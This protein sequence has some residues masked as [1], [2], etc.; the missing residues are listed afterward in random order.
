MSDTDSVTLQQLPPSAKLVY[1][2]LEYADEPL[3][4]GEIAD[5]TMLPQRTVRGALANLEEADAVTEQTYLPDA[6]KNLYSL[7]HK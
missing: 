3:D 6:R 1:K 2:V 7:N 4:Q 5:R